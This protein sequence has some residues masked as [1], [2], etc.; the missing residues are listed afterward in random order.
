M[1]RRLQALATLFVGAVLAGVGIF[2][3]IGAACCAGIPTLVT[4]A[5]AGFG[6]AILGLGIWAFR[7]RTE[8]PVWL[9]RH[10]LHATLLALGLATLLLGHAV[11]GVKRARVVSMGWERAGTYFGQG[12]DGDPGRLVLRFESHPDWFQIVD[13][14]DLDRYLRGRSDG[15]VEAEFELDYVFGSLRSARLV[16]VGE[17]AKPLGF[18]VT[19]GVR[20][21]GGGSSPWD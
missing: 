4:V 6:L 15:S 11:Y 7:C 21:A 9:R 3:S 5:F 19:S 12:G 18:I 14:A 1:S 16:R 13:D 8:R 2:W 10:P 17:L 20:G